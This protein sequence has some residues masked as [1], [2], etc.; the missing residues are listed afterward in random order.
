MEDQLTIQQFFELWPLFG[1]ATLT[2]TFAG[3]TLGILGVHVVLRRMVFL[4][5]AISQ[6][7]SLGVMLALAL[8][9][10][11]VF[12]FITPTLGAIAM[13]IFTLYV[14][15]RA[16]HSSRDFS[17]S[18]L[19]IMYLAGAAGTLVLA[20]RIHLELHDLSAMLFG[21]AVAVLP[22]D[23]KAVVGVGSVI[24]LLQL[25]WW[26]GFAAVTTDARDAQVRALPVRALDITLM[27]C[28]AVMIS[29]STRVL[30]PLPTFAFSILPAVAAVRLARNVPS[31]LALAGALGAVMG[32]VGY[33]LATLYN[34]PVGPAQTCLGLGIVLLADLIARVRN[35]AQ[36]PKTKAS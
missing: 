7:A 28:I 18:M 17:D 34:L 30:G 10:V 4:T 13:T 29:V 36:P 21:T 25:W 11:A 14:V 33:L 19:G 22:A 9:H 32:F 3:I 23:F 1:D 26:R 20:S 2:G 24:A 16:R 12:A 8:S 15:N 27:L 6:S 35:L 31:A 5:A